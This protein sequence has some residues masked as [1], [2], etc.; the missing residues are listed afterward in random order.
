[1]K[2]SR[3]L[4]AAAF[5]T[6]GTAALFAQETQGSEGDLTLSMTRLVLQI[7]ILIFAVKAGGGLARRVRLPS[8]VGELLSGIIV[9]P[10]ALGSI[11]L[12]GLPGGLFPLSG[13]FAVSP[14]LYGF[15]TIASIVLL[16]SS[17][18]ETD[19]DLFL[20]YSIT[21]GVVGTGGVIAS[22]GLGA[23]LGALV[24]G[25]SFFSPQAMFL[26]IMSTATSVG[27]TARILSDRK[28]MDSPEGVTILAAAVFDD[29]LGIVAL[30]VVMGVTAVMT[31]HATGA[32][33]GTGIA[34]IALR[35]FGIWLG[36]TALGL[37]FGKRV[38]ALL[39]KAGGSASFSVLALGLALLL[40]GFFQMQGLAMII[41]A[42]IVGISLSKTDLAYKI[43]EKTKP[44]YDFF[45]P[46]FF[47]A[48][49]MLVD[50]GQILDPKVL[51]MGLAYTAVAVAS[52]VIGCGLPSMFTGFNFTGALRIGVGMVPRGEVALIIAGIGLSSGILE[53]SAFGVSILMTMITTVLAPPLL[54]A[55]LARGGAGTRQPVKGAETETLRVEFPSREL[56]DLVASTFLRSMEREGFLVQLMS[57]QDDIS[58]IRKGDVSISL[59]EEETAIT[60]ETA[61]EDMSFVKAAFHETLVQLDAS[62]DRLKESY[63]PERMRQDMAVGTGRRDGGFRK[64]LGKG[65]LSVSLKGDT[66]E[67]VIEELVDL[68]AKAG[69]LSDRDRVLSDILERESRMSTGMQHGVALPH[70]RTEGIQSAAIAIGILKRGVDFQTIDGSPGR[71]V[72]LI[73]SPANDEAPHMQVLASLGAVLGDDVTREKLLRAASADEALAALEAASR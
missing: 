41:G 2:A 72:A 27:I 45:V 9:G 66:K 32:L 28:K 64:F 44:L 55:A 68:L 8:V 65:C 5:L 19:I 4:P 23:G 6:A 24:T 63:D 30:A 33:S 73:A 61:P 38:A 13:G 31:G 53:Q 51:G 1:M 70:A 71:I 25:T 34:L 3:I 58:H 35:A 16:F 60:L 49:G 17:G 50:L 48:M 22:F 40:A 57:I 37:V 18:L 12:P 21:G 43:Q 7:A 20:R 52:K 39:K 10:Y 42:Y 69:R 46:I 26:G 62:F 36:F 59:I 67:K 56:S 47:A 15:S 29:V 11:A 14:E 54:T